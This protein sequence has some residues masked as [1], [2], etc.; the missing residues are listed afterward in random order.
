MKKE[1]I[2]LLLKASS[3]PQISIQRNHQVKGDVGKGGGGHWWS[4]GGSE[5][6]WG[7]GVEVGVGWPHRNGDGVGKLRVED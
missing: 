6:R 7:G 5:E 4:V 3:S 1:A 2:R